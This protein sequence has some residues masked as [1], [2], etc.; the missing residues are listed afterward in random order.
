MTNLFWLPYVVNANGTSTLNPSY[1]LTQ[2]A[3]LQAS[4]PLGAVIG[5]SYYNLFFGPSVPAPGF[6]AQLA[7]WQSLPTPLGSGFDAESILADPQFV[8]YAHDNFTLK[9][10]SPAILPSGSGGIGFQPI[11]FTGLPQ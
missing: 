5:Y 10:S 2:S 4:P 11:D 9:P 3:G 6:A 8:D 7:T 1:C